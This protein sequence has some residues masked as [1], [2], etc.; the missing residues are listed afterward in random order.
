MSVPAWFARS[1]YR[2]QEAAMHRPTF[3]VLA[4][5]DRTQ[6]LSRGGV[7]AYQA[8][9]LNRLLASALAHSPW[10]ADRLRVAVAKART[11]E[12]ALEVA[13]LAHS[14]HGAIGFTEEYDLQLFTRRLHAWRQAAGSES[15]WHDVL[16]EE[17][18]QRRDGLALDMLRATADLY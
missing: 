17:L 13:A 9:R 15:Y 3:A 10:H 16:G 2:A 14:I 11:S 12:A 1:V 7:E 4:E 5:I 8:Q 18:V 6:W